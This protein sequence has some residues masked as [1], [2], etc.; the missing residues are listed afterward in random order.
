[1][2]PFFTSEAFPKPLIQYPIPLMRAPKGAS[3]TVL[4]SVDWEKDHG[5]WRCP[6]QPSYRGIRS[7]TRPLCELL[8]RL[9]IPCTWFIETNS[10]HPE[11]DMISSCP[12]ELGYL[13]SRATDEVGLHTHWG[14]FFGEAN[15]P[16]SLHD[17]IWW[18]QEVTSSTQRLSQFLEKPVTSFR[19]GGHTLV[20]G[21]PEILQALG[22]SADLSIEDRRRPILRAIQGALGY[23]TGPF[24]PDREMANRQG[25]L[26]IWEIPTSLHL[27]DFDRLESRLARFLVRG[28]RQVLSVYIHID[29]LT[30]PQKDRLE[31]SRLAGVEKILRRLGQAPGVEFR[32]VTS[33]LGAN[34]LA[35]GS[36]CCSS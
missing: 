7:A 21:L 12:E 5:R 26:A 10:I 20:P 27:H 18:K 2:L 15:Q 14:N 34:Q 17:L 3:L 4:F 22:Y 31:P 35:G 28:R 36:H 16:R 8:D 32:T 23:A 30:V 29:E 19:S 25:D 9:Q 24:H 6:E 11:L 1:M 13:R 33:Y